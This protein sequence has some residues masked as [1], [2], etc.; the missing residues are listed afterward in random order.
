[1]RSNRLQG[2]VRSRA[3]R[4]VLAGTLIAASAWAFLPY[5]NYRIASS[6]FVNAELMRVAAPFAGELTSNLPRKGDFID[7]S[8]P[9]SLVEARA[10]DQRHLSHLLSQHAVTTKRAGLARKQ[11]A[12]TT[13]ADEEFIERIKTYRH[14]TVA[15]LGYERDEARAERTGCV[16]EAAQR[17]DIW[18]RLDHLVK[19]GTTTAI[20]S[21]EAQALLET[22]A[23]RCEMLD[24]KLKRLEVE[25]KSAENGVFLR[26]GANDAP[27]SQQQRDRLLLRRQDL[28][29][30]VLEETLQSAQ[31]AAEIEQEKA[32]LARLNRFEVS[33]PAGHV[34][35]SVA[36]SPGS[37]VSEGQTVL[38]LAA[39]Q[40]RFVTVEV[41]L[42]DNVEADRNNFCNIGRLAEVRFQ[43]APPAFLVSIGQMLGRIV[44]G[45]RRKVADHKAAGE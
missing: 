29:I 10:P 41:H 38:D 25:L 28:E 3:A 19:S 6:A 20:K 11:L 2:L 27:Y 14:G 44:G 13:A 39:C 45:E 9:V 24:S 4:L 7:H 30:R 42:P 21:A 34:V 32:R 26:D 22:N 43:R 17:R 35:W 1:M 31:F 12:E 37:S 23:A 16:A 15:R 33:L 5:I 36:A 8:A 18:S 40:N